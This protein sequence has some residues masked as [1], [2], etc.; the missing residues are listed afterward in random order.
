MYIGVYCELSVVPSWQLVHTPGVAA[1]PGP[2]AGVGVTHA[3][4]RDIVTRVRGSYL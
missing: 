1:A 4:Q 2:T 3:L